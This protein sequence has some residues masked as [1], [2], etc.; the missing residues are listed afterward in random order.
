ML[1]EQYDWKVAIGNVYHQLKQTKKTLEIVKMYKTWT[2][3]TPN[4]F[5]KKLINVSI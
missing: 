3:N 2:I 5:N 4:E 1:K